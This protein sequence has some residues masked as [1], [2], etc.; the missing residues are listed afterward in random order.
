MSAPDVAVGL[1]L[2][3]TRL[4]CAPRRPYGPLPLDVRSEVSESRGLLVNVRDKE[5]V[6]RFSVEVDVLGRNSRWAGQ[7][8]S[9]LVGT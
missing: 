2:S 5:G 9:Y 3:A 6:H 7:L 1:G 8:A 4:A